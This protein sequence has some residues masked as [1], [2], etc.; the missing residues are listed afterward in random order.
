MAQQ[1]ISLQS[2]VGDGDDTHFGD[3]IE[4]KSAE[5]PSEMTTYS[6][7]KERLQEVLTTLTD[8]ERQVLDY[9]FGLNR[10]VFTHAGGGRQAVQCDARTHPPDRSQGVAQ[11]SSPR[12]RKLEGFWRRADAGPAPS[13]A[14]GRR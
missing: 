1:P 5:N 8:R 12:L 13:L 3:F 2:P 7:L 14:M 10:R 4:D 6:M 9:R 11:A